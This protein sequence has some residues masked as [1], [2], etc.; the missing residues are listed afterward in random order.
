[1]LASEVVS[2][3][4]NAVSETA[5]SVCWDGLSM[6]EVSELLEDPTG[7]VPKTV[8]AFEGVVSKIME[9]ILGEE[10]EIQQEELGEV[11]KI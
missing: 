5:S 6:G 1:M 10:P 11:P 3:N 4:E 7:C 2:K 9:G 8:E